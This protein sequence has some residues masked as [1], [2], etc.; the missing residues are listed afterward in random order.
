MN[1]LKKIILDLFNRQGSSLNNIDLLGNVGLRIN[2]ITKQSSDFE[3][4]DQIMKYFC[5][6]IFHVQLSENESFA[7]VDAGD[8]VWV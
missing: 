1:F 8:K 6:I 2:Q 3:F 4:D 5:E 7:S